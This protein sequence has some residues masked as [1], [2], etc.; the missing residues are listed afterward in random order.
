MKR[1]QKKNGNSINSI[2]M[3]QDSIKKKYY[4]QYAGH[5]PNIDVIVEGHGVYSSR[6][7]KKDKL[8]ELTWQNLHCSKKNLEE[9]ITD[10]F[11][12]R[13]VYQSSEDRRKKVHGYK[14]NLIEKTT[15]ITYS[16]I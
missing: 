13:M 7:S 1:V 2:N 14:V 6:P 16:V 8:Y 9:V 12:N 10:L 15:T 11:A 4:Y 5:N 3:Y